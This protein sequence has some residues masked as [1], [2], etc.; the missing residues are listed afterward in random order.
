MGTID[1][2]VDK[3]AEEIASWET[4]QQ[5]TPLNRLADLNYR[6]GLKALS[7]KIRGRLKTEGKLYQSADE[8]FAEMARIREKVATDDYR[9]FGGVK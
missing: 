8:I 7:E 2:R 1:S 4:A 5:E 6:R 9:R 3:I